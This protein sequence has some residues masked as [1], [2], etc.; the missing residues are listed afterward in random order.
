MGH[1]ALGRVARDVGLVRRPRTGPWLLIHSA[2]GPCR[3]AR[4]P[5]IQLAAAA[6]TARSHLLACRAEEAGGRPGSSRISPL[7]AHRM[8]PTFSSPSRS[9]ISSSASASCGSKSSAENGSSVGDS[10]IPR[11][12]MS[13]GGIDDRPVRVEPTS[14]LAA[15]AGARTCCSPRHGRSGNT[16]SRP[17]VPCQNKRDRAAT[18]IIWCTIGVSGIRAPAI[19]AIRGLHTPQQ[20]T[21]MLVSMS[22]EVVRTDVILGSPF[23]PRPEVSMP[24]TSGD[25]P[26]SGARRDQLRLLLHQRPRP[27]ASSDHAHGRWK[28]AWPRTITGLIQVRHQ[29][30][31]LGG[32]RTMLAGDR[33]GPG[34]RSSAAAARPSGPGL[35]GAI[36]R[37]R[38]VWV[39]TL[40][41][42]HCSVLSWGSAPIIIPRVLDREDEVGGVPGR[43][44]L[45]RHR[46]L[47]HQDQVLLAEPGQM[48]GQSCC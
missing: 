45:V 16:R 15:H 10:A 13:S 3:D 31:H 5:L 28:C 1:G 22:P 17:G 14:M 7:I 43:A 29:L 25:R 41:S 36:P 8:P 47:P 32:R 23:R 4:P 9:G 35:N 40:S 33:P 18:P 6:T 2:T 37:C 34:R 11:S 21:Q 12:R 20:T 30:R 27:Q 48:A 39:N 24:S 26:R 38:R 46:P 19:R 42:W 44:A